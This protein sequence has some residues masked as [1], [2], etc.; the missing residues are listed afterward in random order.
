M[1]ASLR[2]LRN[3]HWFFGQWLNMFC[4]GSAV[5][6]TQTSR[7]SLLRMERI[8]FIVMRLDSHVTCSEPE[9]RPRRPR[10]RRCSSSSFSLRSS[11]AI[12]GSRPDQ[13]C[14][15]SG[16]AATA[17]LA[18]KANASVREVQTAE[19]WMCGRK[20]ILAPSQFRSI[21]EGPHRSSEHEAA[22][23]RRRAHAPPEASSSKCT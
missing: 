5:V 19:R 12:T 21:R 16:A 1:A 15:S 14:S 17:Y 23:D 6:R 10:P 11:T 2:G 7:G 13:H 20:N 8:R 9:L 3:K 18:Q 22:V 4:G